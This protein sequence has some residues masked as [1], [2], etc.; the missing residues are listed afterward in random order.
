MF[1][2]RHSGFQSSWEFRAA[3]RVQAFRV[4]RINV[5]GGIWFREFFGALHERTCW[6]RSQI[7]ILRV[8]DRGFDVFWGSVFSG[9][10]VDGTFLSPTGVPPTLI[11]VNMHPN[12]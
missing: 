3:E 12:T 10:R 2:V 4:Q 9:I 6:L 8:K 5:L 7:S 1:G 11:T